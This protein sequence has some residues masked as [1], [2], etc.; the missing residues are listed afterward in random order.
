MYYVLVFGYF[1]FFI[2]HKLL[3][4]PTDIKGFR[5]RFNATKK[6]FEIDH[7]TLVLISQQEE[8]DLGEPFID[9]PYFIAKVE[10]K[11]PHIELTFILK[12]TEEIIKLKN[13][14]M[15]SVA[16]GDIV[17]QWQ[18]TALR[19][20]LRGS[21][22]VRCHL[23]KLSS[24]WKCSKIY[25]T[26]E[27]FLNFKDA[28]I[29]D[30]YE[31]KIKS[32]E[33][34]NLISTLKEYIQQLE[35]NIKVLRLR[36]AI[37]K[38]QEHPN[39]QK[40]EFQNNNNTSEMTIGENKLKEYDNVIHQLRREKT[41]LKRETILFQE[42]LELELANSEQLFQENSKLR[43]EM[44]RSNEELIHLKAQLAEEKERTGQLCQEH[45]QYH[46][47][48]SQLNEMVHYLQNRLT[49]QYSDSIAVQADNQHFRQQMVLQNEAL[50]CKMAVQAKIFQSNAE[51]SEREKTDLNCQ[52]QNLKRKQKQLQIQ[53]DAGK[54]L[55]KEVLGLT[56]LVNYLK[57]VILF[58][59]KGNESVLIQQVEVRLPAEKLNFWFVEVTKGKQRSQVVIVLHFFARLFLALYKIGPLSI[60]YKSFVSMKKMLNAWKEFMRN[61]ILKR[62]NARFITL[63]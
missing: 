38:T 20:F 49:I 22:Y 14:D 21:D 1:S 34:Q 10:L 28:R 55:A 12:N 7:G 25:M 61:S 6:P 17:N 37:K 16:V 5:V 8:S 11:D 27:V 3:G 45:V 13:E 62:N 18:V 51:Q 46:Q 60:E 19:K 33:N 24:Q 23:Q 47:K 31:Y 32:K 30:T 9:L 54:D 36:N 39:I 44:L 40:N 50:K 56:V 29:V 58:L 15:I 42:H 63:M 53:V 35:E 59:V 2:Q 48:I 52:N 43:K 4:G 26:S 41:E 57:V